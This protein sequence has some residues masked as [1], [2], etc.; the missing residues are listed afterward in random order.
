LIST[1]HPNLK[2]KIKTMKV[3]VVIVSA[4]LAVVS[5]KPSQYLL[6]A[7]H[8]GYLPAAAHSTIIA[9]AGPLLRQFHSQDV[10]GQYSYG[11]DGGPSAKT[12]TRTWDGVT[13]GSYR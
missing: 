8:N 1:I 7:P 12:E 4:V 9:P 3:A 5:A 10:L 11:Y 2:K 13:R 6:A